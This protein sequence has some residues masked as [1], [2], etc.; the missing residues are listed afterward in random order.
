MI[1]KTLHQNKKVGPH[2]G[3]TKRIWDY[4]IEYLGDEEEINKLSFY[5]E[6]IQMTPNVQIKTFGGLIHRRDLDNLFSPSR[7]YMVKIND[8]PGYFKKATHKDFNETKIDEADINQ[9]TAE[10]VASI[11]YK[12]PK[13]VK[14]FIIDIKK[15]KPSELIQESL[16]NNKNDE[17]NLN[18]KPSDS[19]IT[20]LDISG[21]NISNESIKF[22]LFVTKIKKIKEERDTENL[23]LEKLREKAVRLSDDIV[24]LESMLQETKNEYAIVGASIDVLIAKKQYY[25]DIE[26]KINELQDDILGHLDTP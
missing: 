21:S 14:N 26:R 10:T 23:E 9:K 25:M 4:L 20:N 12:K 11:L 17:L 24:N 13:P 5:R 2:Y 22:D 16:D 3:K 8:K 6:I 15:L 1:Q 18:E 7:K 19:T